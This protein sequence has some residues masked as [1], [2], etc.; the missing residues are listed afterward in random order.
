MWQEMV[1][2]IASIDLSHAAPQKFIDLQGV[3]KDDIPFW[4]GAPQARNGRN[5]TAFEGL[6]HA[7]NRVLL[8]PSFADCEYAC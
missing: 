3:G 5:K 7:P 8:V 1:R 2:D 6:A 4:A